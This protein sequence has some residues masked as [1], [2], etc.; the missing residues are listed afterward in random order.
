MVCCFDE[1]LH[2]ES[3]PIEYHSSSGVLLPVVINDSEYHKYD[4]NYH[5]RTQKNINLHRMFNYR[6]QNKYLDSI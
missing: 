1:E 4:Y 5:P 2:R 3:N 6:L